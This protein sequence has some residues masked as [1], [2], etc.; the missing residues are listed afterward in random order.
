M[1]LVKKAIKAGIAA[2]VIDTARRPE[3]QAKAKELVAK[4]KQRANS[5]RS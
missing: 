3:N 2:K 1:G 5:R 4:A